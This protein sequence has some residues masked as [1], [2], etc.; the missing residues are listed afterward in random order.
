VAKLPCLISTTTRQPRMG[1][2]EGV[3]YYFIDEDFSKALEKSDQFAELATYRGIRY[4]VTKDEFQQKL[5]HGVAFLI[6]EPSGIDNYVKPALDA[7]AI[8]LK[9]YIHT[10]MDVRL[11]RFKKRILSDVTTA[12]EAHANLKRM[13][14]QSN[15]IEKTLFSHIDRLVSMYTEEKNWFA[16][17]QWDRVLFGVDLPENNLNIILEDIKKISGR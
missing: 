8:H 12:S 17:V 1:E 7:G 3:D 5:S 16:S 10:D 2:E 11:E 4:G 13:G 6:V 9:Y 15:T 14:K